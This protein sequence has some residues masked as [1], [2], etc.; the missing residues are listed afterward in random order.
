MYSCMS[1]VEAQEGWAGGFCH[2][3]AKD[4]ENKLRILEGW[5]HFQ[6]MKTQLPW[7][8]LLP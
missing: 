7:S 8:P 2:R 6:S 5:R 4:E 1:D 3:R